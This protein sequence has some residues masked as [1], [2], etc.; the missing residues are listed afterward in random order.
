MK[1]RKCFNKLV[2]VNLNMTDPF[3]GLFG[4]KYMYC[5]YDKC[6]MFGVVVVAGIPDDK[7]KNSKFKNGK[8]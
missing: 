1:C 3:G 2:E 5:N 4:P 7:I 8:K 6:D